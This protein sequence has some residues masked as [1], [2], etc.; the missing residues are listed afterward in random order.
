MSGFSFGAQNPGD[1]D[2]RAG[3][4]DDHPV[5]LVL[6]DLPFGDGFRQGLLAHVDALGGALR[7]VR[8]GAVLGDV[9]VDLVGLDPGEGSGA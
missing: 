8:L 4:D 3:V 9:G 6:G 1:N 2:L 7:G 5:D